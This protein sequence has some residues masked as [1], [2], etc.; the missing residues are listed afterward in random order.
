MGRTLVA[1]RWLAGSVCGK[2]QR[3]RPLN[4]VVR[5]HF[6]APM[7]CPHCSCSFPL[8]W[9]RYR[10]SPWGKHSCPGCGRTS[11][12]RASVLFYAIYVPVGIVF[13]LLGVILGALAF[14]YVVPGTIDER[15]TAYFEEGWWFAVLVASVV[16]F[17]PVDRFL[18]ERFRKLQPMKGEG[19]A[20]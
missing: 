4:S 2:R 12:L 19:N 3:G 15:V 11:R 13:Q 14:A 5:Q 20:V 1:N 10:K 7:I 16:L 6:K 18:D 9:S 17:F 8:S